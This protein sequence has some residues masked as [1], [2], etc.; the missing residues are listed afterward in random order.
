MVLYGVSIRVLNDS[1]HPYW[2][3]RPRKSCQSIKIF[4]SS[5]YSA[6]QHLLLLFLMRYNL[7]H[8][9]GQIFH[10]T[11]LHFIGDLH[12]V[13]TIMDFGRISSKTQKSPHLH[14]KASK[15]M[16]PVHSTSSPFLA[17]DPSSW[18]SLGEFWESWFGGP[19]SMFNKAPIVQSW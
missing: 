17:H 9:W 4:G 10:I 12:H 15:P 13:N 5:T 1:V 16:V 7:T 6:L 14:K 18:V 8:C 2:P 3:R 19:R 11:W